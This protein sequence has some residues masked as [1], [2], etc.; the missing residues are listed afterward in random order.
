MEAIKFFN[1]YR[2]DDLISALKAHLEISGSKS[3]GLRKRLMKAFLVENPQ[4]DIEVF[5]FDLHHE[6]RRLN[7]KDDVVELCL[8]IG[9]ENLNLEGFEISR[10]AIKEEERKQAKRLK[11]NKLKTMFSFFRTLVDGNLYKTLAI[12]ELEGNF[13]KSNHLYSI[14]QWVTA[15][16]TFESLVDAYKAIVEDCYYR[17]GFSKD[18]CQYIEDTVGLEKFI[19]DTPELAEFFATQ[20]QQ[21]FDWSRGKTWRLL[22]T[23]LSLLKRQ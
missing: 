19:G 23:R 20:L 18:D 22:E 6:N 14:A 15:K 8:I 4:M 5:V 12:N 9:K 17:A 11:P 16:A 3:Q 10:A 21:G 7:K 13:R 2:R 1:Q